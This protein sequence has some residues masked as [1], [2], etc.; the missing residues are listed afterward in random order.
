MIRDQILSQKMQNKIISDISITPSEVREIFNKQMLN[1]IPEIPTKE[2]SQLVIKPIIS[3]K[4][5]N[6][7]KSK[8][9]SFRDRF[10]MEK[11]LQCL[12]HYTLMIQA[13]QVEVEN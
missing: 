5:K 11:T 8:L 3:E 9:N 1:D 13:H 4:Q 7:L 10:I 2:V 6:E 12:R